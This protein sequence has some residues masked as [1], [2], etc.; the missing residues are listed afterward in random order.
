[1]DVGDALPGRADESTGV[2]GDDL[3]LRVIRFERRERRAR[4]KAGYPQAGS[5][6]ERVD[7]VQLRVPQEHLSERVSSADPQMRH[8]LVRLVITLDQRVE[9]R[10]AGR[11]APVLAAGRRRNERER[12]R[13]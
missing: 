1:D 9:D 6:T 13:D 7:V 3:P 12:E 11:A 4:P 8:E 10:S 2:A 5:R